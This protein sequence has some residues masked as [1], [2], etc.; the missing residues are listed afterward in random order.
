MLLKF[1]GLD[2]REGDSLLRKKPLRKDLLGNI[3]KVPLKSTILQSY[4]DHAGDSSQKK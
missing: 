1:C 3:R 2:H 4:Y